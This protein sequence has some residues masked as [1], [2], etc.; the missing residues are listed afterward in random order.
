MTRRKANLPTMDRLL[1]D[2]HTALGYP[3]DLVCRSLLVRD[4]QNIVCLYLESM[5]DQKTIDEYVLKLISKGAFAEGASPEGREN[6][7]LRELPLSG[8][9]GKLLDQTVDALIE[10]HCA[11]V[12]FPGERLRLI[13]VTSP[14]QRPIDE[15]KSEMTIRGP[16]E[17]FT[18]NIHDNVG[19]IRKRIRNRHLRMEKMHIGQQTGTTVLLVYMENLAPKALIEEARRRLLAIRTDS[20]LESAYI[21]EYIQDRTGSPFPTL[22]NTERPDVVAAQLLDGKVAVLVDGTPSAL[23]APMTFFEFFSSPEDYYQ[24][25]DIATLIRWIRLIS[26]FTAVFVPSLYVA[27]TT[28]HQE[29]IPPRLLISLSAQREGVPLPAFL[30]VLLMEVVF[31]IIREAGLRMPR[32]VGQALSIVGAIVLGQSAVEAGLISAA[33]VIVVAITGI[34][35]FVV[36][37]YS[38][39]MSQRLLR[40]SFVLLAGF[41]GLFGILCGTLLVVA[42]LVSLRSFGVP[43]M[44]PA[45]PFK[46]TDWKDVLLRLPRQWL[47]PFRLPG[48]IRI[49]KRKR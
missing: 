25:A 21:E 40:F 16:R 47:N 15:P 29:L 10:G 14:R 7:F 36:P 20:V 18:E 43:Y 6:G 22:T 13:K 49:L 12:D 31:E 27:A 42:H 48:V 5:A 24:R 2:V 33:I 23:L 8:E 39:G 9:Y 1:G 17:G 41:M 37:V 45:T 3:P 30:E 35:N 46:G 32:A 4:G 34:T 26:F 11:L 44:A 28:F 38:F 19:L